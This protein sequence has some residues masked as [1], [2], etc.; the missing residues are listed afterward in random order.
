M[1]NPPASL[2]TLPCELRNEIYLYLFDPNLSP[3]AELSDGAHQLHKTQPS[4]PFNLPQP[5][6]NGTL[7]YR[8]A[9]PSESLHIYHNDSSTRL[10]P[11]RTCKQIYVEAHLLALSLTPFHITGDTTYPDVFDLRSRPL[12]GSL[13]A[14][15]HITLTA[16]IAHLRA[17]NEAWAGLPFGHPNLSLDTLTIVPRRPDASTT[18]FGEIADLS[19]SHTLAYVFA[20]TLKQLRNVRVLEVRN[21]GCFNE[22]VWR[23]V[24]RSLVFRMWRWGGARCGVY[25]DC[26]PEGKGKTDDG[27]FRVYID[28]SGEGVGQGLEVGEEI[29]RLA[30]QDRS[31][32]NPGEPGG[33]VVVLPVVIFAEEEI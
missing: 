10:T 11:L 32:P 4:S 26:G 12:S 31:I 25:F 29:A 17:L 21:S 22:V 30:G 8:T 6:R 7:L 13:H 28:R 20:E 18:C 5:C 1:L 14:V 3:S 2:L 33:Q 23:I 9:H 15:R 19:Q 16:R 27:W 24:Y